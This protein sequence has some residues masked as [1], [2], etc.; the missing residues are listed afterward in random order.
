MP[1]PITVSI[2]YAKA[3]LSSLLAKVAAGE[4]IIIAKSGKPL[5]K[6]TQLKPS[7][8][9]IYKLYNS[10]LDLVLDLVYTMSQK[11]GRL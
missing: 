8:C 1:H 10:I 11:G 5:A 7:S 2:F 6:L 3:H 9:N 4:E